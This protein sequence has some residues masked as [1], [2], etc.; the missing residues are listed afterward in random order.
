MALISEGHFLSLNSN[1]YS[2]FYL[3]ILG[4][5]RRKGGSGFSLQSFLLRRKGESKKDFHYNP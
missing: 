1:K 2:N 3:N 4:V 5:P